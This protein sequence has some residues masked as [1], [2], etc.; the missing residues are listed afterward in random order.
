MSVKKKIMAVLAVFCVLCVAVTAFIGTQIVKRDNLT[1]TISKQYDLPEGKYL[2]YIGLVGVDNRI[3]VWHIGWEDETVVYYPVSFHAV[4]KR[5]NI[6]FLDEV[7]PP[8]VGGAIAYQ[9][10]NGGT[11]YAIT[12]ANS[13]VMA[14]G[15]F[16]TTKEVPFVGYQPFGMQTKPAE[17]LQG[18]KYLTK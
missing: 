11:S 14:S 2:Q 6:Y 7:F 15:A 4:G 12:Q 17:G 1:Q 13:C 5:K 8:I 16:T 18:L 10:W 9:P 3:M